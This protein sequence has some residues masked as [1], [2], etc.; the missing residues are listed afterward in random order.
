M[1]FAC[2]MVNTHLVVHAIII[3]VMG[4]ASFSAARPIAAGMN[5]AVQ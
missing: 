3:C 1:A 5:L 2:S 4:L